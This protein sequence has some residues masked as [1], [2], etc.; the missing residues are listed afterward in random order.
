MR[1]GDVIGDIDFAPANSQHSCTVRRASGECILTAPQK[2]ILPIIVPSDM[3]RYAPLTDD[4]LFLKSV[5]QVEYF[6]SMFMKF[7]R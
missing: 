2:V 1:G 5:G 3:I 7:P 6:R 4:Q